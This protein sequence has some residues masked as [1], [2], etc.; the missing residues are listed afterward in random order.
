MKIFKNLFGN[1][2]KINASEIA[3]KEIT[4]GEVKNLAEELSNGVA[5]DIAKYGGTTLDPNTTEEFLVLTGH[6]NA[7]DSGHYFIMTLFYNNRGVAHN[8]TQIAFGYTNTKMF[9]RNYQS[10][11][12]SPWVEK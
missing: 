12:W 10:T 1:G 6:A 8:K 2:S 11:V 4:S 5:N 3:Y 9:I 7:P